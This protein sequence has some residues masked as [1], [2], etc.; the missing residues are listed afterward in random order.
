MTKEMPEICRAAKTACK[1]NGIKVTMKNML[2]YE[3]GFDGIRT[4]Y[5]MFK[6]IKTGTE[7]QC[8]LINNVWR[9]ERYQN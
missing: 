3:S 8:L 5:V 2:I 6:D 1:S 7:Y 4:K 9:V